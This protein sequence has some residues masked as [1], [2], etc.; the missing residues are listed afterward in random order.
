MEPVLDPVDLVLRVL[1]RRMIVHPAPRRTVAY[2]SRLRSSMG[3]ALVR[4]RLRQLRTSRRRAS[5]LLDRRLRLGQSQHPFRL[6]LLSNRWARLVNLPRSEPPS[7]PSHNTRLPRYRSHH[8]LFLYQHPQAHLSLRRHL[9]PS[10]RR[11]QPVRPSPGL[12]RMP[13]RVLSCLFRVL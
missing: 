11:N 1:S 12:H 9:P 13:R 10:S 2:R 6:N 7:L 3:Q 8:T 5:S 4:R